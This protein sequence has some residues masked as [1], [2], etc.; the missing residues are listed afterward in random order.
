MKTNSPVSRRKFIA[1]TSVLLAASQFGV[2]KGAEN[3]T[4]KLAIEGGAKA[5][6]VPMPK[7]VRWGKPEL[8]QL[9]AAVKQDSLYY[10][11]NHQTQLLI[12]RHQKIYG[13]EYVQ[14]C[15]SGTASLHIAAAAAGI[16][17]GDE[18]I[19]SGI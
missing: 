19:T 17:P 12:E 7:P 9:A 6:T 2:V 3:E 14:P 8:E 15:S 1:S 13:H 18:V 11:K 10:W 4:E 5:V 16:G